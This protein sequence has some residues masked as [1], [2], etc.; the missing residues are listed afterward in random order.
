MQQELEGQ[1]F[2]MQPAI[3]AAA[4]KMYKK[5]PAAAKRFLTSYSRKDIVCHT[6]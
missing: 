1:F 5:D 6:D 4:L 3:E 2:A